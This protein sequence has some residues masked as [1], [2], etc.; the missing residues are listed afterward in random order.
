MNYR[1]N[2][3]DALTLKM[4]GSSASLEERVQSHWKTG[5]GNSRKS[6]QGRGEKQEEITSSEARSCE[7]RPRAPTYPRDI[8]VHTKNMLYWVWCCTPLIPAL[9]VVIDCVP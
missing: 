9:G 8:L 3:Q 1:L 5:P 4:A 7:E 6:P 2:S